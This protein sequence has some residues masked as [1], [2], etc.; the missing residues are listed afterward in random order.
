MLVMPPPL[1]ICRLFVAQRMPPARPPRARRA[2]GVKRYAIV[3]SSGRKPSE[4]GVCRPETDSER[5]DEE[6]MPSPPDEQE[7][8]KSLRV[9]FSNQMEETCSRMRRLRDMRA[10]YARG[11]GEK[12]MPPCRQRS[13][14]G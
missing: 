4:R 3:K 13:A 5:E 14:R 7:R 1:A 6:A 2:P 11:A 9:T 8:E 10:R 12:S